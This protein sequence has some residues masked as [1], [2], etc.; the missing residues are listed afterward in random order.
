MLTSLHLN[1]AIVLLQGAADALEK[2]ETRVGRFLA[3]FALCE[4]HVATY[5]VPHSPE[6]E[7]TGEAPEAPGVLVFPARE[8]L[9]EKGMASIRWTPSVLQH[10]GLSESMTLQALEALH[11]G[12]MRRAS[13]ILACA[14]EHAGRAHFGEDFALKA[15]FSEPDTEPSPSPTPPTG[16]GEAPCT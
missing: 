8:P 1:H 9:A 12:L 10:R 4:I 11:D 7:G 15:C 6:S 16:A 5:P 13:I 14:G 2:G 3:E